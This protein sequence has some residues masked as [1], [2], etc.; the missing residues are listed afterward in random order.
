MNITENLN[1]YI[2]YS[3]HYLCYIAAN[4]NYDFFTALLQLISVQL[5]IPVYPLTTVLLQFNKLNMS[6]PKER[7]SEG[8]AID[9]S[10]FG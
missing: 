5:K 1:I 8:K 7:L 6:W 4:F 10:Q 2:I 9:D 3:Y